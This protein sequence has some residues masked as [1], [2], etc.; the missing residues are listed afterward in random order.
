LGGCPWWG[1]WEGV[2][3]GEFEELWVREDGDGGDFQRYLLMLRAYGEY[4]HLDVT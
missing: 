4:T 1:S 2:V 3:V